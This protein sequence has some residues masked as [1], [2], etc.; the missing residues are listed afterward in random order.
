MAWSPLTVLLIVA[1]VWAVLCLFLAWA[2]S[3][4]FRWMRGDFDPPPH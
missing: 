3:R 4:F 1:G 2:W